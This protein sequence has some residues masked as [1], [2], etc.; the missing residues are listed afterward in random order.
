MTGR[1]HHAALESG[2]VS[3]RC[4]DVSSRCWDTLLVSRGEPAPAVRQLENYSS[5]WF[6]F[7]EMK[8]TIKATHTCS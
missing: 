2:D 4:W 6:S 3:S 8:M 5:E 1:K 7:S